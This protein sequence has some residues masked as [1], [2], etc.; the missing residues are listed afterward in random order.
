[1]NR[2][3]RFSLLF[4]GLMLV[5]AWAGPAAP[6]YDRSYLDTSVKPQDDFY[7]Y[8]VGGY[9]KSHPIPADRSSYGIDAELTD[10]V[11]NVLH[12]I[13]EGLA[14]AQ[15]AS[16]NRPGVPGPNA[17]DGPEGRRGKQGARGP[18]ASASEEQKLG[19]FYASGMDT[20]AINA[21]GDK[22]LAPELKRI[23]AIRNLTDLQ[24]EIA[25][26]HNLEVNAVFAFGPDQDA[27]HPDMVLGEFNQAGLS[28]PDRD[29]YLQND[30]DKKRVRSAFVAHVQKTFE[31]MGDQHAAADARA[32]LALET[33]LAK[34]SMSADDM[35]DPKA[36]YNPT[37][38]ANLEKRSPALDWTRYFDK[39]GMHRLKSV[40]VSE[41]GFF[42]DLSPTLH[43]V[44]LADWKTYLRWQ[45]V[46]SAA[47]YLS[48]P[49]EQEDFAFNG[50]T[51]TGAQQMLPRWRRV[52]RTIDDCMG[53][54]LGHKFVDR[55]FSP[56]AKARALEMVENIKAAVRDHIKSGWMSPASQ[57]AAL[58]KVD[59]LVAKIG[60]PDKWKDYSKLSI[61][62]TSYVMNVL[63]SRMFE[64]QDELGRIGKPVDRNKWDM[65]PSTVNAYYDAQKNEIVFPAAI[66]QPPYFDVNAD[67]AANY[68]E[69]G[70]TIG[71]ELTHGFDD[72]GSQFD[73]HGNLR[74][75][76]TS[77][78]KKHFE[79]LADA[80]ATQFSEF[81]FEGQ[82]VD[83]KRVEGESIADLGGL[84]LAYAAFKKA[85]A[86]HAEPPSTDGFTPDQ[87]FFLNYALSWA[88][89]MRSEKAHMLISSNPHP[90]PQFR[91]DGPLANLPAFWSAFNVPADTPMHRTA[92]KRCHLWDP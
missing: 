35:R 15:S 50:R 16:V 1:M 57:Q 89:N 78:D 53:E 8:A 30:A 7:Q 44:S 33:R 81:S 85:E 75:W 20:A 22:P 45:L 18:A 70:A 36:L 48:E 90:L 71:H 42:R 61:N 55:C 65:T 83:G 76:W 77:Q 31:L 26:L 69:T 2:A 5:G 92:A 41:P 12:D 59:L 23:D 52:A 54:A 87:R 91:V 11:Q 21:A 80:V 43:Q 4:A 60:Y 29:Y 32:E 14:K 56:E 25:R 24:D 86:Q 64:Q 66:L 27:K 88:T 84:E 38:V 9:L 47:P 73:G 51:M 58:Q 62:R 39:L 67:D 37:T 72:E 13:L 46:D 19:D 17:V 82:K 63:R 6:G 68:G 28:L 10:R 34:A 49:F 79:L 40:N 3:S 74:D